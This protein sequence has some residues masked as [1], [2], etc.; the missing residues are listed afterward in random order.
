[1]VRVRQGEG[2]GEGQG[3]ARF[4]KILQDSSRFFKILQDSSRFFKIPDSSRFFKI[5]QDSSRFVKILEEEK[6]LGGIIEIIRL[7]IAGVVEFQQ[8]RQPREGVDARVLSDVAAN[9][10]QEDKQVL[11]G[12]CLEAVLE[13]EEVDGELL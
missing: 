3:W 5:R 10:H 9:V 12:Q 6:N 8:S 1:M 4:F 11:Q 13:Q 2:E 7:V